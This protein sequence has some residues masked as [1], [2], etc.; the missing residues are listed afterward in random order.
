MPIVARPGGK[1]SVINKFI[2]D[3]PK[4]LVDFHASTVKQY[5]LLQRKIMG[6]III[7]DIDNTTQKGRKLCLTAFIEG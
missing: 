1:K 7:P 6:I 4:A 5:V 2:N 3:V